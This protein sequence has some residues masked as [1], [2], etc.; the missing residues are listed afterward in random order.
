MG[1]T[2]FEKAFMITFLM[3]LGMRIFRDGNHLV[4]LQMR[5]FRIEFQ[6]LD[7]R[8]DETGGEIGRWKRVIVPIEPALIRVWV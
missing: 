3:I 2:D 4:K 8:S 7:A 6:H 5:L 1:G